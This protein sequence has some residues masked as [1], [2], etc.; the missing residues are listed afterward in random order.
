MNSAV[1]SKKIVT[2]IDDKYVVLKKSLF[3]ELCEEIE[4]N[5]PEFLKSLEKDFTG[6]TKSWQNLKT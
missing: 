3:N 6:P 4:A 1:L 2:E 5:D